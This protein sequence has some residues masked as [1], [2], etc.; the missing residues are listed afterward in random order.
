MSGLIQLHKSQIKFA[1]EVL[2]R[3][4]Q[5]DPLWVYF[6]P[7]ASERPNKSLHVLRML[8][9][10]AV[11]Y[12]EVHATS[13]KLEGIAVW[14][15]PDKA[16]VSPWRMIQYGGFSVMLKMN[17][18]ELV[19]TIRYTKYAT[20]VHERCANMRHWYLQFIGVDPAFQGKGYASV[21]LKPML[22][23]M[24][25]GQAPCYLETHNQ[26]NVPIYQ[27]YG[28]RV[29]EEGTIPNTEVGCWAMLR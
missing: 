24:D 23:R 2:A 20:S 12:G 13:I 28:F 17:R 4:F 16:E 7:N 6:F 14:L 5:D 19:R 8:V 26:E 15:P 22:A 9:H 21:L 10:Y 11:S 1:A 18:E 29:V 3:A 25:A 27:H